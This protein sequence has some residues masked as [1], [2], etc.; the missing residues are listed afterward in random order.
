MKI[1][2]EVVTLQEVRDLLHLPAD[3]MVTDVRKGE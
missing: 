3:I 2:D 1:T